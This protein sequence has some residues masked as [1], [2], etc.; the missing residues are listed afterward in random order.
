MF[1]KIAVAAVALFLIVSAFIS[2]P[3]L[4]PSL[5]AD[6]DLRVATTSDAVSF[7]PYLTT[8]TASS[9]YQGLVYA[10]G[11]MRRNPTT[12]ELEPLMAKSW[13]ISPDGLVYTFTLRSDLKWSD[14]QPLTSADFKFTYDQAMKPDNEYPYR[15]NNDFIKSYE[16]PDPST[17]VVTINQKFCPALEGADAV[18]PLPK[19]IWEKLDWK[20]PE[21]NREINHPSVASG[22]F[23]FQEWVKDDHA[24]FVANDSYFLGR[25]KLDSYTIQ[26]VP[27][28]AVAYSMLQGNQ[29]DT[30]P[31]TPEQFTATKALPNLKEYDWWLA[32]GTWSYI[33]FN[34]RRPALQDANVRHALSY[35]FNRQAVIDKVLYGLARPLYSTVVPSSNY[36]NPNVQHY[37]YNPDTARQLLKQAGYTPGGDGIL[38]KNGQRLSLRLLFGPNSSKTREAIAIVAQAQFKQVGVDVSIQGLEWGAFLEATQ[39]PPFDWDLAVS[40]W[41]ATLDPHWMW[42]IWSDKFPELDFVGYS[43]PKVVDLFNQGSSQCDNRKP[44]YDQIQQILADDSPYIFVSQDESYAFYNKRVGGIKPTAIGIDYN[45]EQW[46]I[47]Q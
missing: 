6:N 42:Q 39:K 41:S 26:I 23:K 4:R 29:V 47:Q 9:A 28:Q 36:Y 43:N 13:T 33:G 22:P 12:M 31:V 20:D 34:L 35:A 27:E 44:I 19:H 37:D 16:A 10:S 24:I 7:H 25:P 17:I 5:A 32:S 15:D 14:G 38:Q 2:L 1:V 21:K 40:G 8:D 45:I 3:V 18:V 11:L 30:A 46:F